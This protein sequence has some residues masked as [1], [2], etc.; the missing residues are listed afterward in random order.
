M[1]VELKG[2]RTLPTK[3]QCAILRIVVNGMMT[4]E[5]AADTLGITKQAVSRSLQRSR[6]CLVSLGIMRRGD[7]WDDVRDVLKGLLR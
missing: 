2:M 1:T 5:E 3:R 7:D 4:Q 6:E